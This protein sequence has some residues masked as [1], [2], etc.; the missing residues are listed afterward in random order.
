MRSPD[1]SGPPVLQAMEPVDNVALGKLLGAV[2]QDLLPRHGRV[3]PDQVDRVLKL[4][5]KAVRP[6][7]LIEPAPGPDAFGQGLVFQPVQV[8]IELRLIG[9]NLERIH[10][11]EPPPP[12][13]FQGG[14]GCTDVLVLGYDR[15]G[16]LPVIGLAQ[17]HDHRVLTVRRN[18]QGGEQRRDRPVV[19]KRPGVWLVAFDKEWMS[20]ALTGS[21]EAAPARF[22]EQ[23]PLRDRRE[24]RSRAV[25]VA[26]VIEEERGK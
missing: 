9:L 7:G 24:S 13:F 22:H 1:E 23:R 4:I 14:A 15:F 6:A 12:G 2:Q 3:H 11:A 17:D 25:R 21:E 20:D 16:F 26:R 8:T 5:A 18:F 19:Q 10:Q